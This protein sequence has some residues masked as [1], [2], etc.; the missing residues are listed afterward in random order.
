MVGKMWWKLFIW[1]V[2]EV[3]LVDKKAAD[4]VQPTPL[5][6]WSQYVIGYIMS[7]VATKFNLFLCL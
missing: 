2:K 6:E 3:T 1:L 4:Y 5:N 7:Y